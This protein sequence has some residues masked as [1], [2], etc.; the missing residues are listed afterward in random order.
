MRHRPTRRYEHEQRF[1]LSAAASETRWHSG[2]TLDGLIGGLALGEEHSQTLVGG[3]PS[4]LRQ[5]VLSGYQ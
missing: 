1:P 3:L 5:A 4:S 2:L